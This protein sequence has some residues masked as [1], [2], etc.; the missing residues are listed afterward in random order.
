MTT[1]GDR[2]GRGATGAGAPLLAGDVVEVPMAEPPERSRR[3]GAWSA[4]A[5]SGA[6]DIIVNT[7]CCDRS[8][9]SIGRPL[10]R[11]AAW[12]LVGAGRS[13]AHLA[14]DIACVP[15]VPGGRS[16]ACLRYADDRRGGR[17]VAAHRATL[18]KRSVWESVSGRAIPQKRGIVQGCR[19][20]RLRG[21]TRTAIA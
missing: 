14:G 4:A 7:L 11:V 1:P 18:M 9:A 13:L 6:V 20:L 8:R 16:W 12:R 2:G 10:E 19:A 5:A 15:G 3:D 21:H 17:P